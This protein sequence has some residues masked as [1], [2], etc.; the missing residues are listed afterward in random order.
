MI[1][2][3]DW[4]TALTENNTNYIESFKYIKEFLDRPNS[5]AILQQIPLKDPDNK[6][7]LHEIYQTFLREFPIEEY[8]VFQNDSHNDGY[9]IMETVVITKMKNVKPADAKFYPTDTRLNRACAI[10]IIKG[11]N[12]F[13]ILGLHASAKNRKDNRTYLQSIKGDADVIV[14]DFNVGDYLES[15]NRDVFINMLKKHV[16]I[17]NLPTKRVLSNGKLVRKTCIDHVFIKRCYVTKCSEFK[18]HESI[19]YSDHYPITFKMEV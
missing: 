19:L 2:I 4:N 3:M 7:N 18:I 12:D 14:G 11:T 13:V 9:I 10:K 5:I 16:C 8:F 17:C 1:E 15:E 6:W